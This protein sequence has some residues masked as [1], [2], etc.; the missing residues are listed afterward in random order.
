MTR[1][2]PGPS[3]IRRRAVV[4][5]RLPPAA[6]Q[7]LVDPDRLALNTMPPQRRFGCHLRRDGRF[8]FLDVPVG[9]YTLDWSDDSGKVLESK[10]VVVTPYATD[11]RMPV[12]QIDLEAAGPKAAARDRVVGRRKP[13]QS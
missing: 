2:A 1:L 12:V 8:F 6:E 5:G 10:E 7:L 4:A 9:N 11:T 3:T 13:P